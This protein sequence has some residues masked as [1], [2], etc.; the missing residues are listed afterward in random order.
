MF[1]EGFRVRHLKIYDA[2]IGILGRG[3]SLVNFIGK[4][5]NLWMKRGLAGVYH[6]LHSQKQNFSGT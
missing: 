1:L 6:L 5:S 4:G 2:Q 3:V